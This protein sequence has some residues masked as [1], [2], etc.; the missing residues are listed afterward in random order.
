LPHH[1]FEHMAS[2]L[3]LLLILGLFVA[4]LTLAIVE[5]F[6]PGIIVN[7][8]YF[9]PISRTVVG[10][11]LSVAS[12]V[13]GAPPGVVRAPQPSVV[14]AQVS[15]RQPPA[16]NLQTA[17]GEEFK[18]VYTITF[19]VAGLVSLLVLFMPTRL[20]HDLVKTV[21]FS[22]LGFAMIVANGTFGLTDRS[23]SNYNV[24]LKEQ[25]AIVS[26]SDH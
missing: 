19:I 10:L 17:Q 8:A 15:E 26:M 16:V 20:N 6:R 18:D 2:G 9:D 13:L 25:P 3:F 5:C 1:L 11:V 14:A 24:D 21:A 4:C 7:P 22:T 23:A 12:G